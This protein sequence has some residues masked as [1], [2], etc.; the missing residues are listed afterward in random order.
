MNNILFFEFLCLVF[1]MVSALLC[2]LLCFRYALSRRRGEASF[3]HALTMAFTLVAATG[4]W[5]GTI[6][7]HTNGH[8]YVRI[9]SLF[10][11]VLMLDQVLLYR[12]VFAI[13]GTGKPERFNRLHFV[14]PAAITLLAV[15]ASL[16]IP[17]DVQQA[18]LEGR[19]ADA[20]FRFT[21]LLVFAGYPI[22]FFYN[23]LYAGL[24]FRRVA[25]YRRVVTDYSADTG[26]ASLGWLYLFMA[27]VLSSIPLP[28]SIVLLE[29]S[30]GMSLLWVGLTLLCSLL[31]VV[32][33]TLITYNMIAGNYVVI[34]P[35][36]QAETEARP[37][38]AALERRRFE[39]YIRTRKPFLNP[40]LRITDMAQEL[41]TNRT[42]LSSLI[43]S[44]YGMNFS[45]YINC[46]RLAE[47]DKMRLN[48][49]NA[50]ALGIDMVL[51]AGFGSYRSYL[52]VKADED[53]RKVVREFD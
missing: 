17:F 10:L 3:R 31:P 19:T 39:H 36:K 8:L 25:K 1:P 44:E 18:I 51:E 32:Q 15:V 41:N 23:L 26:H 29:T 22:F 47:L 53:A 28:V 14:V 11:L 49:K 6:L 9:N 21:T 37:R 4:C 30:G 5:L 20:G 46:Q 12:F 27:L 48:P 42:Y 43:N 34:E 52:R 45:R 35:E 50:N 38:V 40:K 13:T 16:L 2:S 24:G 7:V 33:Y